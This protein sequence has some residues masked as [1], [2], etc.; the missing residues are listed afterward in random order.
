MAACAQSVLL[1]G[2][3]LYTSPMLTGALTA[4]SVPLSGAMSL[5][6]GK[7]VFHMLDSGMLYETPLRR[8]HVEYSEPLYSA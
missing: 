2:C 7:L 4:R 8:C 1:S 3:R 5:G 6:R